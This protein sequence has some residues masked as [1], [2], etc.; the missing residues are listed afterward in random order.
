MSEEIQRSKIP[1]FD[2]MVILQQR[3]AQKGSS[4]SSPS[5]GE[6]DP[7][8]MMVKKKEVNAGNIADDTPT[9]S[10]P[11]EDI[12]KLEDFC[13]KMG[14]IGFNCGK[15]SPLAALAFLKQ[16]LGILDETPKSEGYGPNYPYTEAIKKKMLLH[17]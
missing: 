2:A 4:N 14:I 9:Q 1:E 17:G 12:K 15:M 11:E 7:Y 3:L 10:W 16:K 6:F 13:K 5:K 8:Q